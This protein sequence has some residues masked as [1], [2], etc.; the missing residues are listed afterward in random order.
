M[1]VKGVNE[2]QTGN[3]ASLIYYLLSIIS[4]LSSFIYNLL[5][6]ISHLPSHTYLPLL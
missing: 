6:I 5:S 4:Y 1:V 2:L 3:A